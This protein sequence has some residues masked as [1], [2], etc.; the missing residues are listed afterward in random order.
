[1]IGRQLRRSNVGPSRRTS[2]VPG[3]RRRRRGSSS[4]LS[5]PSTTSGST[6]FAT[7][8]LNRARYAVNRGPTPGAR[9]EHRRSAAPTAAER[10]VAEQGSRAPFPSVRWHTPPARRRA[11][12]TACSDPRTDSL[13]PS[14]CAPS[15]S[16][17][18]TSR[19][20]QRPTSPGRTSSRWR[21]SSDASPSSTRRCS[22]SHST[23]R[24]GNVAALPPAAAADALDGPRASDSSRSRTQTCSA[25]RSISEA[26]RTQ[27]RALGEGV[28]WTELPR[29]PTPTQPRA[30]LAQRLPRPHHRLRQPSSPST[31]HHRPESD[32]SGCHSPAEELG[33]PGVGS[34]A[35]RPALVGTERERGPRHTHGD[36][37]R[38]ARRS[39]RVR[40]T[41]WSRRGPDVRA[42]RRRTFD[43]ENQRAARTGSSRCARGD[44]SMPDRSGT[45][46]AFER[47]SFG[48]VVL[49]S[50]LPPLQGLPHQVSLKMR[51]DSR[52]GS[53]QRPR[54]HDPVGSLAMPRPDRRQG[55]GGVQAPS[56]DCATQVVDGLGGVAG[57]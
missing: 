34:V 2:G 29:Q 37:R 52:V 54:R 24:S 43:G 45:L 9:R 10:T 12:S 32:D 22:R 30:L 26:S 11:P 40:W 17:G 39:P 4:S 33:A 8:S 13:G 51:R 47:S 35:L 18:E 16:S 28:A 3:L 19:R 21:S 41:S 55:A 15:T 46:A 31:M 49:C 20:C 56:C 23:R 57:H 6:R 53:G 50:P 5:L 48:R 36:V 38:T 27:F 42:R 1:M 14:A 7:L 44:T 25:G